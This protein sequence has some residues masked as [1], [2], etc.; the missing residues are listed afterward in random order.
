[1]LNEAVACI[2]EGI[3]EDIEYIDAASVFG[4]GFAPFTGGIMNYINSEGV[5]VLHARLKEL[6]NK[7]GPR[8]SSSKY[9]QKLT[10]D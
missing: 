3:I 8:F 2:E 5:D 9:W 6:E 10:S 4:F 7:Y 1:M